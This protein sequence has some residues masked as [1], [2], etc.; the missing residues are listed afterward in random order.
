MLNAPSLIYLASRMS[1]SVV[2][3]KGILQ[4]IIGAGYWN[5]AE[6]TK[7]THEQASAVNGP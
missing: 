2:I 1:F 4:V 5:V 6:G 7:P 3:E